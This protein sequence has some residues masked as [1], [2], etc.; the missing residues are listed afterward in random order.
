MTTNY[1]SKR[2]IAYIKNNAKVVQLRNICTVYMITTDHIVFE[3]FTK[4][5][6][7]ML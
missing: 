3:V 4:L 5:L 7:Q 6:S 2:Y 1:L